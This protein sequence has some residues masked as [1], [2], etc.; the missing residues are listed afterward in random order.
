[1]TRGANHEVRNYTTFFHFSVQFSLLGTNIPFWEL[2]LKTFRICSSL[3]QKTKFQVLKKKT[4]R[5]IYE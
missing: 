5:K 2:H 3:S 1:M 4:T